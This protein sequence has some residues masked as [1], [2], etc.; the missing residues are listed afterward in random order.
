MSRKELERKSYVERLV[1]GTLSLRAMGKVIKLS[2]RQLQ[3]VVKRYREE[4]D[5]GRDCQN[6][7]AARVDHPR[8]PSLD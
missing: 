5:A 1:G 8:R 3:R 2:Y 7:A 6:A 4:G